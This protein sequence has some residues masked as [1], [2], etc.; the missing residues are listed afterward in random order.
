MPTSTT[1]A[2]NTSLMTSSLCSATS[3]RSSLATDGSTCHSNI[4]CC[5]L[6]YNL[7]GN[8]SKCLGSMKCL[9]VPVLFDNCLF[10][11]V[12]AMLNASNIHMRISLTQFWREGDLPPPPPMLSQLILNENIPPS[13]SL[14]LGGLWTEASFP[15][16]EFEQC[17][18]LPFSM[19]SKPNKRSH[20]VHTGWLDD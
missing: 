6:V 7:I 4:G 18:T 2:L 3:S 9:K 19:P 1:T 12:L 17:I 11:S 14:M 5:R 16:V 8:I 15:C 20:G 10:V 13:P